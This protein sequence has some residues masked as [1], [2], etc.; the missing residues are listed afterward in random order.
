L[1]AIYGDGP[2]R[3]ALLA[4]VERTATVEAIDVPGF[5]AGEVV[6]DALATASCMV[7]PSIREGYGLVVVEALSM[8]TPVVVVAGPDNATT[9]LIDEGV[10]GFVAES[11]D[12]VA[13]GAAI[14]RAVE[15]AG[16]L[17]QSTW[18]W[19]EAHRESLS[20]HDSIAKI[21]TVYAKFAGS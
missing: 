11:A 16:A 15:G 2:E 20:I 13:L 5:V 6:H 7:L 17:R 19:Y 12:P 9:E 10:N 21:E 4:E 14:V 8:G 18:D 3:E 1:A